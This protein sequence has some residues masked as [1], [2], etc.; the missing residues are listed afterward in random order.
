MSDE[1]VE[2]P[3]ESPAAEEPGLDAASDAAS[4]VDVSDTKVLGLWLPMSSRRRLLDAEVE[5]VE[6]LADGP[7][8]VIA[9]TRGAEGRRDAIVEFVEA[10]IPVVVACHPGAEAAAVALIALGAKTV[11]AEGSEPSALHFLSGETTEDLVELYRGELERA[12]AGG[13]AMSD[14]V[15][16]LPTANRFSIRLLELGTD[17][18]IPRL[19][20]AKINGDAAFHYLGRAGRDALR[21]RLAMGVVGIAGHRDCEAF[22]LGNTRIALLSRTL[23]IGEAR[24]IG[25]SIAL[26]ASNFNPSG[27]PI[28]MAVGS[29]GPE[30]GADLPALLP[31]AE[32]AAEEARLQKIPFI[33]AVHLADHHAGAVELAAATALADAVDAIDPSGAHS[34]RV[35]DLTMVLARELNLDPAEAARVALAARLH[36]LGKARFSDAA[37]SEGEGDHQ[38]CQDEHAALGDEYVRPSGGTELADLIRFHH[39]HWDGSGGPNGLAGQDIPIGSR[40]IAVVD[41]YDRLASSGSSGEALHQ[42]L[43]DLAGTVLDPDLVETLLG[44]QSKS[45][46]A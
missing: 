23:G 22:D 19:I 35:S 12:A 15:T 16:G 27:Q 31:L 28:R 2:E 26:L 7:G 6:S 25:E 30:S 44:L 42:C 10:G 5:L 9:S 37:F 21:R 18:A 13:Q 40:M 11:V 1:T 29:A 34:V 3:V 41:R 39:E 14:S 17:G 38:R 43:R 46:A 45:A 4:I 24:E 33:D 36:D 32:R 20:V 8:L